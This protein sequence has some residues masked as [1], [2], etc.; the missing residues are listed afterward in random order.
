MKRISYFLLLGLINLS[1]AEELRVDISS[2][3]INAEKND[4]N[5]YYLCLGEW[6][7]HNL[8][9]SGDIERLKNHIPISL[10]I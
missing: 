3:V 6:K 7:K 4:E 9:I 10:V 8:Q 2:T 1:F 5:P